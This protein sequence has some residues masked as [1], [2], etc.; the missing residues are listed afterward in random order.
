MEPPSWEGDKP[1]R[2][3]EQVRRYLAELDWSAKNLATEEDFII[4]RCV[5]E[6]VEAARRK[7]Y[8][9]E[10]LVQVLRSLLHAPPPA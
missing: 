7:G 2:V 1:E 5:L 4:M 3:L 9:E 10:L 6:A 8:D